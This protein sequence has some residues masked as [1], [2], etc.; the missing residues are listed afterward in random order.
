M[1]R[2]ISAGRRD[3]H[4]RAADRPA[5]F[6]RLGQQFVIEN[7]PGAGNNIATNPSSTQS[8][9][10]IPCCWSIRRT[11]STPRFTPT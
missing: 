4:H 8:P 9:T 6:E 10:A 7:K 1:G 11:T 5:A 2:R 3:R